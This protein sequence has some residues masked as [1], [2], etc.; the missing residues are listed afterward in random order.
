MAHRLTQLAGAAI[1][2]AGLLLA[3]AGLRPEP[4][5]MGTSAQGF[6]NADRPGIDN[7][8]SPAVAFDPTRPSVVVV[9]DRIDS[10]RFSCSLHLSTTAGVTW[11]Q[12]ALPL[13]P[14]APNCFWPDVAFADGRM[15]VLYSAS[16]GRYNQ[17]LGVWLQRFEGEAASGPPVKV[18]GAEA[19]HAHFAVSGRRV[20]VAY[21]QT[22]PANADRPLGFEPGPNPLMVV[23]SEDGGLTFSPP[24]AVSEPST[25]PAHPVVLIDGSG[26][27]QHV[28]VGAL[29]YGDDVDNYEARHD[30]AG[31]PPPA[32]HWRIVAWRSSDGGSSFGPVTV[33]ADQVPVPQ[34]VVIDL[35]PGPSFALDPSGRIYAAWDG[36]TGDAR[37]V[38]VARS[39][40]RGAT[41]S[42]PVTVGPR[43]RS[44]FL[45]AIDVA[46][47]GRVDVLFYDRSRD[48]EDVL[49]RPVV[50]SSWDGGL[51]F[52]TAPV[53]E[54]A[55]DSRI[56]QGGPQAIP[57]LGNQL[58]VLSRPDGYLAFWADPSRPGNAATELQDLAV[59][60]VTPRPAGGRSWGLVIPGILVLL[61]AAAIGVRAVL[62]NRAEARGGPPSAARD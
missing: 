57:Q 54:Q 50:G 7:H 14:D 56:G 44:Q 24:V 13:A 62:R 1:V 49:V 23:R 5:R 37:D 4:A 25:R 58:A 9:A 61:V 16:G 36:G 18:A 52:S 32:G 35:S 2:L 15:Y 51:T 43:A 11:K 12:L 55:F 8:N 30:G 39:E 33:V 22:P 3:A 47:D 27:A 19:F 31:G 26:T 60:T 21:V 53:S 42:P 29:D 59:A 38:F 46:P 45:P 10:P 48:P 17:P 28:F 6:V 20:V 40:D 34:R 41:W